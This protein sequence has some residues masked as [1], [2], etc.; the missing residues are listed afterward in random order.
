MGNTDEF[1]LFHVDVAEIVGWTSS[2]V[3]CVAGDTRG[4]E[5]VVLE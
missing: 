3:H 5:S 4:E 1:C 2:R